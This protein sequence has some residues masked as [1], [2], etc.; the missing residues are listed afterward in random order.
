MTVLPVNGGLVLAAGL[1]AIG[2]LGVLVR[3]NLLY[4]LMC[5]EIMMNAAGLAFVVAGA[6]WGQ[7]DGQVFFIFIL[8]VAAAEVAVG[9]ALVNQIYRRFHTLDN[10]ST[11][12]MRG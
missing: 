11:S 1:F 8:T 4:T 9:L 10:D 5:V 7:P 6:K 3:R 12:S 2:L